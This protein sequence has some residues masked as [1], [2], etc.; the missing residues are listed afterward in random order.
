MSLE[1]A[2]DQ[3][4][5]EVVEMLEG[6]R[7]AAHTASRSSDSRKSS[8]APAIRS[9]LD[10]GTT[11]TSQQAGTNASSGVGGQAPRVRFAGSPA[12]VRSMLDTSSGPPSHRQGASLDTPPI[13]SSNGSR[14][15]HRSSS[16]AS[17]HRR[18]ESSRE[19]RTR[20]LSE[21]D[22]AQIDLDNDYQFGNMPRI[23]G[24]VV[25]KR[26]LQG[27]KRPETGFSPM[28]AVMSGDLSSLGNL[29]GNA[30]P[31]RNI[32]MGPSGRSAS[33]HLMSTERSQS[34]GQRVSFNLRPTPGRIVTDRGKVIDL[35]S[36]YRRLSDGEILKHGGTLS[37]SVRSGQGRERVKSGEALSPRGGVRLTEDYYED[38]KERNDVVE[39]SDEDGQGDT[40]EEEGWDTDG[41]RGRRRARMRKGTGGTQQGKSDDGVPSPLG[42]GSTRTKQAQS[43]LAAAEEESE[44]HLRAPPIWLHLL[45]K[46]VYRKTSIIVL[47]LQ[48]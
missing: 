48:F 21:R 14:G 26:V 9:M 6:R 5:R 44:I 38:E 10:V 45:T 3:E 23:A 43:L 4:R 11:S 1:A 46:C 35:G 13:T 32:Q 30:A 20:R 18:A 7:S 25:P 19:G 33:P 29:S 28:A 15:V 41:S 34:P 37:D 16:D 22:R 42:M 24:Q 2:L 27:G 12:P 39:S 40:S 31:E 47:R 36:A 17:T 8:P